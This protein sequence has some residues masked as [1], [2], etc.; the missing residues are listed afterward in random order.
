[1]AMFCLDVMTWLVIVSVY[2][3]V[4]FGSNDMLS[5]LFLSMAMFC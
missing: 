5:E 2:G 1:M 3:Y 4:L